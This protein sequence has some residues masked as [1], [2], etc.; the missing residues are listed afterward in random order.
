M[1]TK[2]NP[3]KTAQ[4]SAILKSLTKSERK[5]IME[6]AWKNFDLDGIESEDIEEMIEDNEI[7]S[8]NILTAANFF[9]AIMDTK[10]SEDSLEAQ[11]AIIYKALEEYLDS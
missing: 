9:N 6:I 1:E 3:T 5:D 7:D 11:A 2:Y 10:A 8:E 4:T